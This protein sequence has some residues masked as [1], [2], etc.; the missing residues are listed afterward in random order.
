MTKV[1]ASDKTFLSPKSGPELVIGTQ[2]LSPDDGRGR[3]EGISIFLVF[4]VPDF[5]RSGHQVMER[6]AARGRKKM[7]K[8]EDFPSRKS[9]IFVLKRNIFPASR[10]DLKIQGMFGLVFGALIMF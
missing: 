9:Q 2:F 4:F 3:G 6:P 1:P 5:K 8:K 7:G 10:N